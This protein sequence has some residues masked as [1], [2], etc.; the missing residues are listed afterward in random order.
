MRVA[1]LS[2]CYPPRL[3]GIES[4]VRDLARHLVA[5]GHH[6]E[7]FTATAAPRGDDA[8]VRGGSGGGNT[9][10]GGVGDGDRRAVAGG[11]V[12]HRLA[13][14]LPGGVPVNPFAAPEVRRRLRRGRFDVV[15]AHLGVVSPF[16]TD[17]VRVAVDEGLPV[18]ATFHCVLDRSVPLFRAVGHLARWSRRGVALDAVSR[19]AA[20]RVSAAAGGARVEVLGN[21]IDL[22]WWRDARADTPLE[23]APSASEEG[24]WAASEGGERPASVGDTRPAVDG[25]GRSASDGG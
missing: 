2:D 4:Q 12:V 25:G 18:V 10:A 24:A 3:G 21:G 19:M 20:A 9:A 15:H 23:R 14:P 5:A 16:A 11:V 7:V 1:V 13:L 22:A 6:V 17:L 8:D